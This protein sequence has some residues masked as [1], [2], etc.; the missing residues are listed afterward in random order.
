MLRFGSM[1]CAELYVGCLQ[2]ARY[3][4]LPTATTRPCILHQ[5][6]LI[7]LYP[8]LSSMCKM[9]FDEQKMRYEMKSARCTK[10]ANVVTTRLLPKR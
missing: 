7:L 1:L 2:N 3:L 5:L 9:H 10:E 8:R 4:Q 6:P